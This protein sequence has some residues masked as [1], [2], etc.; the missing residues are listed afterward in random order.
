MS[1][2]A[3]FVIGDEILHGEIKDRNGPWIIEQLNDRGIRVKRCTILP[4]DPEI[5]GDE[6]DRFL[7][8][9]YILTTGGIGPTHDDR[10]L[11]GVGLALDRP[12][13]TDEEMLKLLRDNH[14]KLNQ[15]QKDMCLRPEGGNFH[16]LDDSVGLAFQIENIYVFPGFPELLEPLFFKLE[17]HFEGSPLSTETI[18]TD[19]LESDIAGLLEQFQDEYPELEFG[20]YPHTDGTITLK[21]RGPDTDKVSQAAHEIESKL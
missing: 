6:I 1:T 11:E 5:I 7:T 12:L 14:G 4:D 16:N 9:D 19:G 10:T 13:T 2:A 3:I 17:D 20:S 15:S 18:E 21:I 8:C